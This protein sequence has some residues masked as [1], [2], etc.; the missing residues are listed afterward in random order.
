MFHDLGL[1]AGFR[2]SRLRFEV[3]GANAARDFLGS[4]GISEV[5]IERV[6]LAIAVHTTPGISAHLPPIVALTAEGVMK[7]LV[8]PLPLSRSSSRTG[9]ESNE[10]R[11]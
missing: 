8:N 11:A 1:T 5:D 2:E 3:D 6:W 9:S 4:H 7:D 10:S